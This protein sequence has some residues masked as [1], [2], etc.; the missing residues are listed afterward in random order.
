[1]KILNIEKRGDMYRVLFKPYFIERVFGLTPKVKYYRYHT[2][3]E[4]PIYP[5]AFTNEKGNIVGPYSRIT[6][7]LNNHNRRITT[8]DKDAFKL[9]KKR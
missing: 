4:N 3:W 6:R 9:N 2:N 5:K 1:M 7:A 8:K